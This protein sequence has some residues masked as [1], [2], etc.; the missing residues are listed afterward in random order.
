MLGITSLS[1]AREARVSRRE[2]SGEKRARILEAARACFGE[3]GFAGATVEAIALRAGVSNGLLYQFFRGK[4]HLFEVV[5]QA[6]V[7]D[8]VAAMAPRPDANESA[9]ETLAGMFR[10]SVEFCRNHPLL[11]ALIRED[12]ALQL[13]RIRH[14][15]RDRV[16]PHR[17]CVRGVLERGVASGELRADLDVTAAADVISQLQSHYSSRA[18]L[19]DP[20]Y[21]D[22]PEQI[23]GTIRF[24]LNAVQR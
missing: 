5:L 16:Q 15:G 21:P 24:V 1:E 7:A 4:D 18:Y 14:A 13:Y 22:S 17:D 2:R 9:S 23:E 20:S 8:W 6:V 19:R 11:P 12:G 3:S 10:R